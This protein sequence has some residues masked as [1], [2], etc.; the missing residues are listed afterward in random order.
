MSAAQSRQSDLVVVGGGILGLATAREYL[1]RNPGHRVRVLEKEA[2]IAQHQTGHNSGVIHSGIYY[3]PGSLKARMCV[4][5]HAEMLRFCEERGLPYSECGKLIVALD[6]SELPRLADLRERGLS[7]GVRDLEMVGPERMREIEPNVV[8]VQALYAPHTG[9]TNYTA[10]A[11][12][13]AED[14]QAAGGEI[15]TSSPVLRI[16]KRNDTA[17]VVTPGEELQARFVITC[18]GLYSDR[19]SDSGEDIRIVPFRG[20]YFRLSPDIRG[21]INALVYPVPDPSFPFLGVHFTRMIDGDVL[22][23]PNAVLAFA[24]EGYKRSHLRLG[25]F[26]ATVRYPGFWKLAKRYWRTGLQEMY[27]DF[28]KAAYLKTAQRYIPAL[29]AADLLPGPSGVRA[30]ALDL[31]G[32]LVDDF[33]IKRAGNIVHVQN[34]P[35]PAATSSLVIARY[36]VDQAE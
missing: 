1:K 28:V 11:R 8:G 35:S 7:N 17:I 13:Y 19:I 22:V 9:I 31:T 3:K 26:A 30:Q 10:V 27:R 36:I 25:E 33:K 6:Q 18:A 23:G 32:A 12:A 14:V 34:A 21:L 29:T 15:S 4:A 16:E 5:G 20:S 24:Q 2:D